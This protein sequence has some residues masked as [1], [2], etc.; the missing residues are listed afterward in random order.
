MKKTIR[1]LEIT[2]WVEDSILIDGDSSHEGYRAVQQLVEAERCEKL[3]KHFA[4]GLPF[5]C[6]AEDEEDAI[7]QYNMKICELDYLKA[8]HCDFEE[9]KEVKDGAIPWKEWFAHLIQVAFDIASEKRDLTGKEYEEYET[10][11]GGNIVD[12]FYAN[13]TEQD[14]QEFL[15]WVSKIASRKKE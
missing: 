7:A 9:V 10:D 4:K 8:E 1:I 13:F 2:D 12:D 11:G 6:R 5:V 14:A 15:D 3:D